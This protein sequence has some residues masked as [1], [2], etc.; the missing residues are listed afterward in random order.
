[1]K[2]SIG[3]ILTLVLIVLTMT[4]CSGTPSGPA[5]VAETSATRTKLDDRIQFIENYVAFSRDY[6][7][8]DYDVTYQNNGGGMVPGP[9]DWDI[10]LI[11]AVPVSELDAWIPGSVQKTETRPP[12]WLLDLPGSIERQGITEWYC[13]SGTEVGID[14]TKSLVAYRNTTM[15]D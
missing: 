3:R 2:Y 12:K 10:Q 4:G 5:S 15:P 11:A 1:M 13:N 8:L 6:H 7:E 9:S 14:R